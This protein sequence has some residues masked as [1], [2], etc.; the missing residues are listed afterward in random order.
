M[1]FFPPVQRHKRIATVLQRMS[2]NKGEHPLLQGLM[3]LQPDAF[4]PG[5]GSEDPQWSDSAW[6]DWSAAAAEMLVR[7]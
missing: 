7:S 6:D 5:V 4:A 2:G 3:P 1:Q